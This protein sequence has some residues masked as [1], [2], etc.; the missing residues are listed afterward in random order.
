MT[1]AEYHA[2]VAALVDEYTEAARKT[3]DINIVY[4]LEDLRDKAAT[5]DQ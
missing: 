2:Y 1:R 4:V 5:L 3:G